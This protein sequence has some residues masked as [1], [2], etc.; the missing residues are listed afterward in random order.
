MPKKKRIWYPGAIY[1]IM[2]RGNRKQELFRNKID[3]QYYL[4]VLKLVKILST[5]YPNGGADIGEI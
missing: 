1:H 4:N 5:R 3:Y 2:S